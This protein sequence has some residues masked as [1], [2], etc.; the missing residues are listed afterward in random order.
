MRVIIDGIEIE[1]EERKTVLETA[2]ENGVSIPSLCDHP[3]LIPFTGCRLCVVQIKGEKGYIPACSTVVKDGMEIQTQTPR[4][5]KLRK[6]ILELILTEHPNACLICTEKESCDEL[7][8]TIRKV[9]EVTG[10]VLCTNNGRCELQD[11]VEEVKL[12]RVRFPSYYREVEIK[13]SDPFFDRNYNLCIL[14]G[15]CVRICHEVRGL[16]TLAFVQRGPDTIVSTAQDRPLLDSNCQFCGACVDVCP[17]GALSEKAIKYEGLHDRTDRIICPMC[18][19][20]CGLEVDLRENRI[21]RFHPSPDGPV[22]RGQACVKGRFTLKD[23]IYS[24]RRI[25]KPMIRKKKVLQEVTW[26]EALD[27]ITQKLK[28]YKGDELALVGSS[29]MS[30]EDGFVFKKFAENVLKTKNACPSLSFSPYSV[31]ASMLAQNGA[32]P[33]LNFKISDISQAKV[34]FL[35]GS[36]IAVSH[37]M[38]WLQVLQAVKAGARLI[39]A[40]SH[41]YLFTRYAYRWIRLKPGTEGHFFQGLSKI[42]LDDEEVKDMSDLVGYETFNESMKQDILTEAV[43]ATGVDEE[44]LRGVADDVL[45][46]GP[47]VFLFGTELASQSYGRENLA[48]LWNLSLQVQAKLI[49]LSSGSNLRGLFEIYDGSSEPEGTA[50]QV[51]QALKDRQIKALYLAGP[52]ELP[53]KLKPEFL[54][55]Q[56]SHENDNL[57]KADV[58]LPSPT[59]AETDGIFVNTEGRVQRFE[60][61]IE[62]IGD[63]KPDWWIF[64]QLAKRRK[65]DGF[66]YK[67]TAEILRDIRKDCS[68]FA[69]IGSSRL[70][71]EPETFVAK[72]AKVKIGFVAAKLRERTE[73]RL[74]GYP[75]LMKFEQ[76]HDQYKSLVLSKEI[77]GFRLFRDSKWI[78]IAR[79]DAD[80]LNL[81]D[82]EKIE[83]SSPSCKIRGIVKISDAVSKGE[84]ITSLLHGGAIPPSNLLPVKIKRG[85]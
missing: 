40:S 15:R 34:I 59:F 38:V 49:P 28:T 53:R 50:V 83:C 26:D 39:I 57:E 71:D 32:K 5:Q 37:P 74:K 66:T 85:K 47:A 63:T 58:V 60:K 56:D 18:S 54:I 20:G 24:P 67:K 6:Q 2:R 62:P 72:P 3:Q 84:V 11:I 29:Q 19:L 52:F 30:C 16:S 55:V 43:E 10:C 65:R 21:L 70:M 25:Q 33:D 14:C 9:G 35:L 12:N 81:K 45:A 61:I 64:S 41:E 7:K 68:A 75:F 80:R 73:K 13:R 76:G 79:E 46:E 36:N 23:V 27:F 51:A 8:S 77:K 78:Q 22:N 69:Q 44:T 17:T 82:G 4:I 31:Y 1:T 42:I 48:A